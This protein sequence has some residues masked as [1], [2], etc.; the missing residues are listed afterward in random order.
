M[1]NLKKYQEEDLQS[2]ADLMGESLD[3]AKAINNYSS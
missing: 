3:D 2:I 1:N